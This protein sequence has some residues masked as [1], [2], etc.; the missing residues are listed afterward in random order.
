[1][2]LRFHEVWLT[3]ESNEGL[4]KLVLVEGDGE[5]YRS[6]WVERSSL[7][8][9][10]GGLSTYADSFETALNKLADQY[11]K[12]VDALRKMAPEAQKIMDSGEVTMTPAERTTAE[13]IGQFIRGFARG[14]KPEDDDEE[15]HNIAYRIE[16]GE[17]KNR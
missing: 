3:D 14:E 9:E 16:Q 12:V 7:R 6:M 17:W 8:E 10:L 4:L 11:Q 1:M 13:T 2:S 5:S 15:L